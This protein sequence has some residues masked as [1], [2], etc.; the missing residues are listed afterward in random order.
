MRY[1]PIPGTDLRPSAICLG[2]ADFGVKNSEKDSFALA[3]AYVRA[4]G[5]F[6]DT[7]RVYSNWVPGEMS[8]S[9]R[10]LGDWLRAGGIRD[11]LTIA[12]KGAHPELSSMSVP[13]MSA[14]QVRADLEG[15]LRSMRI[16]MIDL[17]YLHRDDPNTPVEKI[18][19]MLDTFVAEGKIRYYG[20]S[21]WKSAR[22]EQA[23]G[24]A[25]SKGT[26]G[27]VANQMLWNVGSW[28]MTPVSDPTIVTF[29]SATRE[30]HRRFPLAAIPYSSQ[31]NGFFS[32]LE[33]MGGVPDDKLRW[34]LY[35]SATNIK[36]YAA[37]AE[38]SRTR[39]IPMAEL[40]LLYLLE[41]DITTLPI[42]GCRSIEQLRESLP[43]AERHLDRDDLRRIC[44]ACGDAGLRRTE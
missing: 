43:A 19:D 31:A 3:D 14:G 40:V 5:T 30:L 17:Y 18:I 36:A 10:I 33:R 1:T 38:L 42:V 8:R 44:E 26:R 34:A 16:D 6:F 37:L 11:T 7:A 12:T 21:N 39:S 13:R 41:Q 15:S 28:T 32:K 9:E 20:C 22:I 2:I 27:F 23:L 25:R 29:D 4:G 35:N 24:Y